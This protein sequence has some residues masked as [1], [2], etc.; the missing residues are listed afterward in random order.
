MRKTRRVRVPLRLSMVISSCP[1]AESRTRSRLGSTSSVIGTS[2]EPACRKVTVDSTWDSP[3]AAVTVSCRVACWPGSGAGASIRTS[4]V[5]DSPGGTSMTAGVKVNRTT[6]SVSRPVSV[7]RRPW[8][9]SE[10]SIVARK[11]PGSASLARTTLGS[12]RSTSGVTTAATVNSMCSSTASSGC[13]TDCTRTSSREVPAGTRVPAR[14]L[15]L[16]VASS[17]LFGSSRTSAAP[18]VSQ[19]G[20][21]G[22]VTR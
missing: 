21:S 8:L 2:T 11:L 18:T 4:A 1:A 14:I 9:P 20:A 5:A 10:L 19:A 12:T 17:L 3:S 16:M 6:P 7:T 13:A 15:S 22:A